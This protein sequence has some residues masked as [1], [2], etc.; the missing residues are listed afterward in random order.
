MLKISSVVV[1]LTLIS[2]CASTSMS[3][4]ECKS[5]DWTDKGKSD[6]NTGLIQQHDEYED[7]CSSAGITVDKEAYLTGFSQGLTSYCTSDTGYKMGIKGAKIHKP[8]E[9]S[10][11][12]AKGYKKGFDI[13]FKKREQSQ[14]ERLSRE[15]GTE[16]RTDRFS[17]TKIE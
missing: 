4:A 15:N 11:Q 7:D 16:K 13:Y 12:Y 9:S 1:L 2:S 17:G 10:E 6:G 5:V 8:C 3:L 14:L